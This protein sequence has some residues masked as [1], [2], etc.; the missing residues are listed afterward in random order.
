VAGCCTCKDFQAIAETQIPRELEKVTLPTYVVEPPDILLI[1]ALRTIPLTPYKI[2]TGDILLIQYTGETP[3]NQPVGGQYQV[4]PEGMVTLSPFYG[5]V[6]LRGLTLEQATT[7]VENQL[8]KILRPEVVRPGTVSVSLSQARGLQ[9]IRGPHLVRPDG[10]ISLGTYGSL[11]VAGHTLEEI[12]KMVEEHLSKYMQVPEVEVDVAGYNSKVYYVILDQGDLALQIWRLPVTGNETVLDALGQLNGLPPLTTRYHV[13][14][15]RPSPAENG[16]SQVMPVNLVG[17]TE[18]AETAT[19]YQ[20]MPGDRVFVK[21]DSLIR[22]DQWL[23]KIYTPVERTFGVLL[24][25]SAVPNDLRKGGGIG[26]GG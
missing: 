17:I 20:V 13:W 4:D 18:C 16:C 14:L 21:A 3:V 25:G 19:N 24:L 26:G 8:K 12:R 2:D 5:G 7:A 22:L 11:S 10:T 15:A 9:Q 23:T 1:D 6:F